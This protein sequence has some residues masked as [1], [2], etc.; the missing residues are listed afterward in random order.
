MKQFLRCVLVVSRRRDRQLLGKYLFFVTVLENKNCLSFEKSITNYV[1][2]Y[3][4][5]VPLGD[6][7]KTHTNLSV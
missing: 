6:F 3:L 4:L 2:Q 1:F 5:K 7:V